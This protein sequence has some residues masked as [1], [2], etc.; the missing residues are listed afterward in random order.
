MKSYLFIM[1]LQQQQKERHLWK[2]EQ[3]IPLHIWIKTKTKN[4][5]KFIHSNAVSLN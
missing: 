2:Y 1:S 4:V 3:A 5:N